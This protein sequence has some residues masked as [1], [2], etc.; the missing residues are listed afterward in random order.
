MGPA[1]SFSPSCNTTSIYKRFDLTASTRTFTLCHF[2]FQ[3][4][5]SAITKELR[6]LREEVNV[7]TQSFSKFNVTLKKFVSYNIIIT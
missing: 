7:M 3:E 5:R 6:T 4:V 2:N 1:T